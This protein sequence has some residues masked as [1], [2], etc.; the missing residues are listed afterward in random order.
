[1]AGVSKR[2]CNTMKGLLGRMMI[3]SS[4]VLI[5]YTSRKQCTPT[6]S[7]LQTL[8]HMGLHVAHSNLARFINFRLPLVQLCPV[9]PVPACMR[10]FEFS[11][12]IEHVL[13]LPGF[14]SIST[15]T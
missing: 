4:V 1:M 6:C 2:I 7:S 12:C 8:M 11:R 5:D 3:R 15:A 10:E 14:S 13:A 9:Q